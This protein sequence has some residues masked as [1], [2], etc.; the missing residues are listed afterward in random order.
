MLCPD[1]SILVSWSGSHF[2]ASFG[3]GDQ[4]SLTF[5]ITESRKLYTT[6]IRLHI[7]L[8][9]EKTVKKKK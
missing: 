5:I 1:V 4:T 7:C 8:V 2:N 9:A 6:I 3:L